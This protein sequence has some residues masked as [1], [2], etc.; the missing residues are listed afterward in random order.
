MIPGSR[1]A[2]HAVTGPSVAVPG[3]YGDVEV[4]RVP[5]RLGVCPS[6]LS[7]ERSGDTVLAVHAQSE[8]QVLHE[9][10]HRE[11]GG[12]VLV[13]QEPSLPNGEAGNRAGQYRED[14]RAI[15]PG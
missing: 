8:I 15:E 2:S 11:H 14:L 10:T 5:Q 4:R 9:I 6:S 13:A 1:A 7:G 12:G 3:D